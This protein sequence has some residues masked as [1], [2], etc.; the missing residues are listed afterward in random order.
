MKLCPEDQRYKALQTEQTGLGEDRTTVT[1]PE[2]SYG[3]Q[4]TGTSPQKYALVVPS[5]ALKRCL[6]LRGS[7]ALSLPI[8][9]LCKQ[10][11]EEG[12]KPVGLR[13]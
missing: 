5:L 11:A 8:H 7:L 9:T 2:L 6:G 4:A 12:L 3:L 1:V 13:E 10:L